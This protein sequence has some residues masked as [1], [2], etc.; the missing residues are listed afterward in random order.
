MILDNIQNL[1]QYAGENK[2]LLLAYDFILNYKKHPLEY[3][4]YELD[5]NRCFAFVQ[6]YETASPAKD[7]EA[8]ERYL[9]LQYVLRGTE[10][11]YWTSKDNLLCTVPMDAQK[12]IAFYA[13]KQ[14]AKPCELV[15]QA[16]EFAIFYPLEP[17]KPGCFTNAPETVE[18]I[19]IKILMK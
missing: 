7:Y 9:D 3:G 10:K 11:M 14:G 19:V 2:A 5:G 8:H 18:K 15:V 13:E 12:D 16:D 17:H 4:R 1:P 6:K